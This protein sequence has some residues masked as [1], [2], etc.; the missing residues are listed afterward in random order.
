MHFQYL[1]KLLGEFDFRN[2]ELWVVF[3]LLYICIGY[4]KQIIRQA[5]VFEDVLQFRLC[6]EFKID[7][8]FILYSFLFKIIFRLK[9]AQR[10]YTFVYYFFSLS[11]FIFPPFPFLSFF[12]SFYF[13]SFYISFLNL[14]SFLCSF[15]F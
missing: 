15:Y 5:H 9:M 11:L 1:V 2:A 13:I 12:L 7:F 6:F 4:W 8:I 3:W 14:S 10:N